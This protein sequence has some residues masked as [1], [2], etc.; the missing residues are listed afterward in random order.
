MTDPLATDLLGF[1]RAEI[2]MTDDPL[3]AESDLLLGGAVDSLGVVRITHWLE[4]RLGA[5]VPAGDI[6]LENFRSVAAISA[7]VER[8]GLPSTSA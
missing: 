1:I 5:P 3:E 7:Y 4:D 8:T 2:A 6:T